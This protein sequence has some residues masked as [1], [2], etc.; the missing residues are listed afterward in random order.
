MRTSL[1]YFLFPVDFQL[2][3]GNQFDEVLLPVVFSRHAMYG[4]LLAAML[5]SL[6]GNSL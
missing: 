3:N 4:S 5:T 2:C 6:V 1:N